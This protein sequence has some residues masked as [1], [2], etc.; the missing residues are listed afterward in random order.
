MGG[1][2]VSVAQKAYCVKWFPANELNLVF[3][4]IASIS[5]MVS[6]HN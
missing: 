2:T 6:R 4:L 5:L 1:E 3:G